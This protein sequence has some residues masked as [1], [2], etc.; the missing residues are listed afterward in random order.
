MR[1]RSYEKTLHLIEPLVKQAGITR[2]AALTGLDPMRLP[3]YTAH[4]SDE[5]FFIRLL[6][7]RG[8]VKGAAK[9]SAL[10]ESL[11]EFILLKISNHN[12][13]VRVMGYRCEYLNQ[14]DWTDVRYPKEREHSW[15]E[16]QTL[17]GKPYLG[18]R[19]S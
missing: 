12:S 15:V 14:S 4:P 2:L 6:K 16:G 7:A 3:V 8:F 9:C 18:C 19:M 1:E 13:L 17:T 11:R 5:S 10:M